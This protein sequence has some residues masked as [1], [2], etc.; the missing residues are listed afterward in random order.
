VAADGNLYFSTEDG[1]VHVVKAG[2]EYEHVTSNEMGEVIWA[3][4]AFTDGVMI[5]R[6][7]GHVYGIA[8]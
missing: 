4:P 2:P 3:T 8:R 6:T 7:L 1:T 5:V